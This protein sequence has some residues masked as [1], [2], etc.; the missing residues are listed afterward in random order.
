MKMETQS[1]SELEKVIGKHFSKRLKLKIIVKVVNIVFCLN[2][3]VFH[4]VYEKNLTLDNKWVRKIQNNFGLVSTETKKTISF[5]HEP[6]GTN[7]K[8]LNFKTKLYSVSDI[9]WLKFTGTL[10]AHNC[11]FKGPVIKNIFQT[12][13]NECSNIC[14]RTQGKSLNSFLIGNP[15]IGKGLKNDIYNLCH[16]LTV[17]IFN[18]KPD[19][20]NEIAFAR[21]QTGI[22]SRPRV[23]CQ[24]IFSVF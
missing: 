13:A 2:F 1:I 6:Y 11:D 19:F 12:K 15:E 4:A 14:S 5:P 20:K 7:I 9:I 23:L 16:F 22:F 18:S 17:I 10:Y 3:I 24:S 8:Y 21:S